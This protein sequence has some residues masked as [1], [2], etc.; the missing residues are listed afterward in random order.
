MKKHRKKLYGL[1]GDIGESA[2]TILGNFIPVPGVGPLIGR[3]GG[4]LLGNG[5][6]SLLSKKNRQKEQHDML[7]DAAAQG[8]GSLGVAEYAMGGRLKKKPNFVSFGHNA[9]AIHGPKHERGGVSLDRNTEVEGGETIDDVGGEPY[10]FSDRLK[11]PG[12]S[13]ETFAD[14][15]KKML[16]NGGAVGE[17]YVDDLA[18]LQ[19]S[20]KGDMYM[21]VGAGQRHKLQYPT[22]RF[23]YGGMLN[24]KRMADG[25]LISGLGKFLEKAT[26][27]AEKAAPFIAPIA[28]IATGLSQKNPAQVNPEP[29][30][31]GSLQALRDLPTR[32]NVN[33]QL[34][35][36]R[37][38][39]TTLFANPNAS[40]A[41]RLAGLASTNRARNQIFADQQNRENQLATNRGMALSQAQQRLD[42][43]DN[44]NRFR[45]DLFNAQEESAAQAAK[46]NLLN[47]GF[48]Q[49]GDVIQQNKQERQI[50]EMEP[51]RLATA[52]AG[53]DE[54]VQRRLLNRL[55]AVAPERYK[56]TMEAL[57]G[58]EDE[59]ISTEDALSWFR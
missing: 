53:L 5:I 16:K 21:N 31:R 43:T 39:F 23:G 51:L 57:S 37:S 32:V 3:L 24:K 46:T 49:F 55:K 59:R 8:S 44:Q 13:G 1:G 27:I 26:P 22:N 10:V 41:E 56:A 17:R 6:E 20:T 25:G 28:N 33:P 18:A 40:S 48:A 45:A 15:H 14:T 35:A 38:A 11:V 9:L 4:R 47:T 30:S 7:L 34:E 50:L 2:G 29:V 19:E 54:A 12:R 58:G 36:T 52:L 42:L